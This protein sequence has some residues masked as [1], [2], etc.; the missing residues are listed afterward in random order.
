MESEDEKVTEIEDR[1]VIHHF[2][3]L[4]EGW[5]LDND[6]WVTD[7]GRVWMTNHGSLY[8]TDEEELQGHLKRIQDCAGSIRKAQD[9]ARWCGGDRR[10]GDAPEK[11][12]SSGDDGGGTPAP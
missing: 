7:D 5:E 4:H 1:K 8:E 11:T 12:D 2:T 3:V 6:G 9:V 10:G